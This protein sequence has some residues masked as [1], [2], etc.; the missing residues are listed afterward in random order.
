MLFFFLCHIFCRKILKQ[1]LFRKPFSNFILFSTVYGWLFLADCNW[2]N[3]ILCSEGVAQRC[4]VEKVFLK[5]FAKFT[6]DHLCQSLFF[7]K[8]AVFRSATLSL[9]KKRLWYRCFPVNFAKFLRT[10]FLTERLR[11]PIKLFTGKHY[12]KW[13]IYS[14]QIAKNLEKKTSVFNILLNQL[15]IKI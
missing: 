3:W 11:W 12:F 14:T 2:V 10:P 9:L 13:S 1:L 6:G 15:W 4:S 8:V 5:I 7:T